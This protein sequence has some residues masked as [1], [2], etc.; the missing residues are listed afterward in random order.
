MNR[1]TPCPRTGMGQPFSLQYTKDTE[2]HETMKFYKRT[3]QDDECN[4]HDVWRLNGKLFVR[5]LNIG[6][7]LYIFNL[8]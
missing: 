6:A 7:C 4:H 8:P 3:S 2:P 1:G 5:V